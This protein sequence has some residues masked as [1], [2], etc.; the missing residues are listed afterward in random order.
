MARSLVKLE[1]VTIIDTPASTPMGI[2]ICEFVKG[3]MKEHLKHRDCLKA[4]STDKL[5]ISH[6]NLL[7]FYNVEQVVGPKVVSCTK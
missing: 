1:D 6:C 7:M 2:M 4:Q 5:I 3:P